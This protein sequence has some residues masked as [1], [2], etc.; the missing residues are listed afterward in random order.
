[1]IRDAYSTKSNNEKSMI[2][3]ILICNISKPAA[4]MHFFVDCFDVVQGSDTTMLTHV[5]LPAT[6]K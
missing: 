6:Q 4:V 5:P 1:M 3:C 2:S